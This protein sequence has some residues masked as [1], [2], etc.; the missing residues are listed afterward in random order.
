MLFR[1][2][3]NK[4]IERNYSPVYALWRSERNGK[5]GAASQSLLWNLYRR[6]STPQSKKFSLLFGLFQYESNTNGRHW[7][8]FYIPMGK[9]EERGG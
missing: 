2:P 8:L 4:S 3:N 5:T 9:T 7:R 6:E 1:S